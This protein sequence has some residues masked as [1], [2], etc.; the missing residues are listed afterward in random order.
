MIPNFDSPPNVVDAA[1]LARKQNNEAVANNDSIMEDVI[2]PD[3][4]KD[5]DVSEGIENDGINGEVEREVV[6][7]EIKTL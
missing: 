7:E 3:I 6:A 5:A 1:E 4:I 2:V